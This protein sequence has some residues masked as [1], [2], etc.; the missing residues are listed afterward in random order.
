M[1]N[2]EDQYM[3]ESGSYDFARPYGIEMSI[4]HNSL[5]DERTFVHDTMLC[6]YNEMIYMAWYSCPSG[7]IVD[8]K[9]G[10]AHV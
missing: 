2:I 10:R 9:I 7:E 8:D 1:K 6:V 3:T 4:V 5:S